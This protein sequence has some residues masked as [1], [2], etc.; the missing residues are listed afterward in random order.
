[1]SQD[2]PL[3]I[4]QSWPTRDHAKLHIRPVTDSAVPNTDKTSIYINKYE[5]SSTPIQHSSDKITGKEVG[6][7]RNF[8]NIQEVENFNAK[9]KNLE[10]SHSV[11]DVITHDSNLSYKIRMLPSVAKNLLAIGNGNDSNLQR[12]FPT[13]HFSTPKGVNQNV[14]KHGMKYEALNHFSQTPRNINGNSEPD[15]P[16]N[17]IY[18]NS[19]F[20]EKA[21]LTQKLSLD[22]T[23]GKIK[24]NVTSTKSLPD[25]HPPSPPVRAPRMTT[26]RQVQHYYLEGSTIVLT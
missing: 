19:D 12:K 8:G 17:H 20:L 21:G 6:N 16:Q 2:R 23:H 13:S 26:K 9:S 14:V 7:A 10:L 22:G 3:A 5:P 11:P 1:M 15:D 18:C 24:W 25:E 4:V